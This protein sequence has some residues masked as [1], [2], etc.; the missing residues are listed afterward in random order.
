MLLLLAAC[1]TDEPT[2]PPIVDDPTPAP[3]E[4]WVDSGVYRPD[5]TG[6]VAL[7]NDVPAH[8]L[9]IEHGGYWE[10]SGTPYD[11]LVGRLVVVERVDGYRPDTSDT[12]DQLACDVG[13][14][15]T[16]TPEVSLHP[17]ADC[18]TIWRV[19]FTQDPASIT[20]TED[21]LDPEIPMDGESWVMAYDPVQGEILFDYHGTG[22]WI[23]WW[24]AAESGDRIDFGWTGVLAV[25][26]EEE[27]P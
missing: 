27:A 20:G 18:D 11:A 2:A 22:V 15:L 14:F 6:S 25:A 17:C 9:S 13:F 8:L 23:P 16:G 21:C 12:G 4:P 19:T 3:T 26:I 7:G 5:D 24:P 1:G 10:Q